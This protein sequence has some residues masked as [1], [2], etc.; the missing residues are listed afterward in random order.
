M[1][2]D[3]VLIE[4]DDKGTARL[5][6]NRPEIHNAFDDALIARL[7]EALEGF[8]RD[9]KVRL[10][11]I[12]AAGKSFSAGADFNWM[13][14]TAKYSEAENRAD[15]ERIAVMLKTLN[16]M[17]KPT[18]ALVQGAAYGGGV[19][20]V[21]CCDIAIASEG[22]KFS[23]S[24]VK[25]GLIPAT[26]SPYVVRAMGA[27]AARRYFLTGEIMDAVEAY[28]LGLVHE[29]VKPGDLEAAGERMIETLHVAGP[30]AQAA[31]KDLIAFVADGKVDDAMTTDTARRIAE[32]RATGEAAEGISAF[33]EKRKAAWRTD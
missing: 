5:T 4:L 24:E 1:S 6:L 32:T 22:A 11:V 21:S 17:P 33:F 30:G 28:R 3:T 9:P 27:R 7:I 23:L 10:V 19:G 8:A 25:I 15:A 13:R 26:I 31:A 18:L 2:Q 29:V 14:R 16:G 20:L 12:A